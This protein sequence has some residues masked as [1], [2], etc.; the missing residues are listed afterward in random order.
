M[1]E[2]GIIRKP[3][4][5]KWFEV[6]PACLNLRLFMSPRNHVKQ[7][8][9]RLLILDAIKILEESPEKYGKP[10]KTLIPKRLPKESSIKECYDLA[11]IYLGHMATWAEQ[12]LEWAQRINN[13]ETWEELCNKPDT[14]SNFRL[15]EWKNG[16]VRLA[17][18]AAKG[19]LK[20]PASNIGKT[21]WYLND[22]VLHAVPLVVKY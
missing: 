13:G 7:E 5:A 3:I 18:G 19:Q 16:E 6:D 2:S 1:N 21:D 15:I 10:F 12:A 8:E 22:K 17:G 11:R 14:I 9:T 4:E 20:L